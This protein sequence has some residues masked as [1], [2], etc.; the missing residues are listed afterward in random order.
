M[1]ALSAVGVTWHFNTSLQRIDRAAAG[2]ALTL[3]NGS[4]LQTDAVLSAV[5][6]RPRI[7]LAQQAGLT[8]NRGIVTD[9]HLRG[10]DAAIFALGDCAE[11]GGKVQPFVLPIM[12]AARALAQT[13]TGKE[14]PVA[15]PTMPVVVK[16]PAHP[17]AVLPVARDA[18]GSWHTLADEGGIKQVFLNETEQIS[19]F[20]LTGRYAAKRNEM[21]KRVGQL[22][23]ATHTPGN[24]VSISIAES[25]AA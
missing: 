12:H 5:G 17:I 13:L 20:V 18:A 4:V 2:Y 22:F 6:L 1:D 10:S 14:T 15:F 8:V 24:S 19:G 23:A 7:A 25:H 9:A 21:N 11:I 16:T 3:A